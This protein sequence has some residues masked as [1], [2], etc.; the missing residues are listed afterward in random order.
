MRT[1]ARICKKKVCFADQG[2]A[3]AV[4]ARFAYDVRPYRCDR[5]GH[6]HL[7]SRLKGKRIPRPGSERSNED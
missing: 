3:M 4:A 6:Y 1:R 2:E 7:T 5:C